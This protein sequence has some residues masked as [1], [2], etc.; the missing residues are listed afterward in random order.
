MRSKQ[1]SGN[2]V[3]DKVPRPSNEKIQPS[4]H[5]WNDK[6]AVERCHSDFPR[7]GSGTSYFAIRDASLVKFGIEMLD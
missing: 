6:R 4:H 2:D 5:H 3:D 1:G 7:A